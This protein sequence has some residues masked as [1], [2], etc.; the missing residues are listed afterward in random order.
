[1]VRE[2]AAALLLIPAAGCSWLLDF[3]DHAVPIDASPDGA[4]TTAECAYKEP[5]DTPGDAAAI[6]PADTGPAAICTTTGEDRDYFRFTL[7]AKTT[8]ELRLTYPEGG[9][10]DLQLFD[11]GGAAIAL[12]HSLGND[13]L[14]TCPG[15]TPLCPALAAGDYRFEVFPATTGAT[16]RYTFSLKLTPR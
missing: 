13:E 12:S 10:L 11:A 5:N 8:L 4:P 3:S 2:C 16:N 1:M 14:I 7:P 15:D 6:T 9:D